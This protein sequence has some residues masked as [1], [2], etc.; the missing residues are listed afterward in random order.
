VIDEAWSKDELR[1]ISEADAVVEH[2]A[3]DKNLV[4]W[5]WAPGT[6]L[7]KSDVEVLPIQK[8]NEAYE[9]LLRSDVEYRF[10]IDMASLKSE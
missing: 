8:V 7:S 10:S 5:G 6:D 3:H 9:R 2:N 4:R 1:K